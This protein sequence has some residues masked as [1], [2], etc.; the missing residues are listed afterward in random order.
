MGLHLLAHGAAHFLAL[1]GRQVH[2]PHHGAA[3]VAVAAHHVAVVVALAAHVVRAHVVFAGRSDSQGR[4]AGGEEQGGQ[5][6][7]HDLFP[8]R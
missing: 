2:P 3:V 4:Q 5:G 7:A 6:L 1:L 8:S